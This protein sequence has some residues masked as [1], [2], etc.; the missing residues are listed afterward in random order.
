MKNAAPD[1]IKIINVDVSIAVLIGIKNIRTI[2]GTNNTPPPIPAILLIVPTRK[3]K[4]IKNKIIYQINSIRFRNIVSNYNF[5]K[6]YI[7][8][9]LK[10][11]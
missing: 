1:D 9:I 7:L 5:Y 8:E 10:N 11:I 2:I 3:P 6:V 4:I